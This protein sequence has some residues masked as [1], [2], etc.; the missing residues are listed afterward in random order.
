M[1]AAFLHPFSPP[2][3]SNWVSIVRGAGAKVFDS[4]G[5]AYVDGLASLWYCQIGHGRRDMAD[6]IA[7]QVATLEAFHTF[8]PYTN[9]W[10]EELARVIVERSPLPEGRAFLTSSGSE[11]VDSVI[12]I[13][14]LAQRLA[15]HPE[16]HIIVARSH[17]YHG[18][19]YGGMTAQGLEANRTGFG[20]LVPGV[21]HVPH[22]D[23]VELERVFSEHA[24]EIA[25]VLTEPIQGAGGVHPPAPGF[26]ERA[27]A[28]C[29]GAGAYLVLDEVICGFGRLGAWFGSQTLGVQP[30]LIT[31]AKG[32]SSGYLPVGGVVLSR[33][34]AALLEA[35]ESFVL[36]HG[37]T[38]S[39]HPTVC[40]AALESI[41]I[42]ER[43]ELLSRAGWIGERLGGALQGMLPEGHLVEVRGSHGIWG[44]Q[45]TAD[46]DAAAIRDAMLDHGVIA[47]PLPG[48]V[49]AWCPPLVITD[50]EIDQC[51]SAFRAVLSADA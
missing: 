44:A 50:A 14:R 33:P 16:R 34:I 51:M 8:A 18:V 30:D 48:N 39:G 5:N 37:F 17:G 9:P 4:D 40:R 29:D 3:R 25:A 6:A 22:H 1:H 47:R 32:V 7:E 46:H 19:T 13:A 45:L 20:A 36:R 31:F 2:A 21:V 42:I 41:R 26:M 24:G 15:G 38:Y 28:L 23:I 43:E 35:D 10:A 12:K 11:S 49:I 27:R